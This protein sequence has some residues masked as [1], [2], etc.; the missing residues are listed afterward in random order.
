MRDRNLDL[1]RT[2]GLRVF[3]WDRD[4]VSKGSSLRA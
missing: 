4:L 1:L 3:T 2:R